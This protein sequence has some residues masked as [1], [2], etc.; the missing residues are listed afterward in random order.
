MKKRILFIL[1]LPPPVHGPAMVGRRI[2]ESEVVNAT[3]DTRYVNLSTSERITDIGR[4][5]FHKLK[6]FRRLMRRVREEVRSFAP[7]LVY[8]TPTSTM[9]G[10]LKD[11]WLVRTLKR[12]GCRVIVHLHNKGAYRWKDKA[13]ARRFYQ[14]FFKDIR[15]I[16]LSERLFLDIAPYASR[17]Q[18]LVC[19]N[20]IPPVTVRPTPERTVPNLLF[21]S[22]LLPSKGVEILLDACCILKEKG[23]PFTCDFVGACPASYP[24]ERFRE[25]LEMRNLTDCVHYRGSRS[26]AEK[27][28]SFSAADIFVLPTYEDS[29]PLVILE[30]MSAGLPVVSTL[31]GGIP[32]MVTD[33][34]TG[35]LCARKDADATARALERLL[36]DPALRRRLGEK[37]RE[38]Y[39]GKFTDACFE[40]RFLAVLQEAISS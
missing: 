36:T 35:I 2:R 4:I 3:F 30:A 6:V 7:D 31:E 10:F 37:G 27:E 19:P 38:V 40:R 32:D 20:G 11:W 22:N 17:E 39:T 18:I 8:V 29:F 23:L 14:S 21:L 24:E 13:W 34:E 16:L 12:K 15:V 5:N 28:A 1:H 9:P 33:G 25:S 26:G